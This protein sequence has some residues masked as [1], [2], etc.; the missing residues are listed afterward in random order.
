MCIRDR[1]IADSD[2]GL[3]DL[4]DH[5][6]AQRAHDAD[7][8]ADGEAKVL[9]MTL[10]LRVSADALYDLRFTDIRQY[11]RHHAASSFRLLVQANI[12]AKIIG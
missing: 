7:L 4:H 11:Q 9:K 1:L 2:A 12:C 10:R 3:L 8:A 5:V 6:S